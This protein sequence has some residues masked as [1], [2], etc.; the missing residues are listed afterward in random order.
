MKRLLTILL[1]SFLIAG[2]ALGQD[3]G[4]ALQTVRSMSQQFRSQVDTGKADVSWTGLGL[5]SGDMVDMELT[6]TSDSAQS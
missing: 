4:S 2:T 5:V 3:S 6:N 1:L